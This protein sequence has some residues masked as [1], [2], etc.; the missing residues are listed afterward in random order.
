M[1]SGVFRTVMVLLFCG[2]AFGCSFAGNGLKNLAKTDIDMVADANL[3]QVEELLKELTG[4]LYRRNP[5][6]L[7]KG[8]VR[9]LNGRLRQLYGDRSDLVF[10]ELDG[11]RGVSA[12]LLAFEPN[13]G[14]DRVFALLV[15]LTSMLRHSY[16]DQTEF[17]M[18][19]SLDQ[20]KLYNSARNIEILVW[21]LKSRLDEAGRPLLLTN[22]LPNEPDNLSFERL[23][24]KLIAHQDLLA[25]IVSEK[26]DRAINQVVKG[27]A[28][29]AFLPVGL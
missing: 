11:R 4:K 13:Y 24:G 22:S 2:I 19:D 23:F 15:G 18:L 1:V 8:S 14:G 16:N 12:L 26:W 25:T 9:S 21:R 29:A 6:E 3:R 28:S 27:V 7:Q 5:R 17:F 20:Q 10:A